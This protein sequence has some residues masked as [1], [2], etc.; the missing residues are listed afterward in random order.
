MLRFAAHH[1]L[2]AVGRGIELGPVHLHRE[3]G[4]GGIVDRHAFA[5]RRQPVG[6][7]DLGA[8][9]G[10]VPGEDD[11]VVLRDARQ[12]GDFA[13]IGVHDRQLRQLELLDRVLDPDIAEAFPCRD[14]RRVIGAQHGPHRA[15][16]RAGIRCRHDADK[17]ILRHAEHFLRQVDGMFQPRLA[18]RAAMR[19]AER[20]GFEI[21]GRP[22]LVFGG[23]SGRK[24]RAL[25]FERRFGSHVFSPCRELA[26]RWDRVARRPH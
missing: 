12:I 21:G 15:F 7:G 2:P 13:I 23:R 26:R 5:A 6:V 18:E 14:G 9:S 24:E 17:V 3:D 16:E 8:R 22:A 4:A 10:A 11:V 1:L 25:G 20:F 19:A